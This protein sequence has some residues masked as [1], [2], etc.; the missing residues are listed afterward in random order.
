MDNKKP[1]YT[2][3]SLHETIEAQPLSPSTSA[4]LAELIAQSQ[5]LELAQG[6]RLTLY[7][8][9]KCGLFVL[10]SHAATWGEGGYLTTKDIPIKYKDQILRLLEVEQLPQQVD[11]VRFRGHQK[12]DAQ[13]TKRQPSS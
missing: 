11:V 13:I 9:C 4:Q 6:K 10:H 5:A 8:D 7:S 3:V 12:E 2:I 1:G